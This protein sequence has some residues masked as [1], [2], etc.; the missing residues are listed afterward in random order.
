MSE[1]VVV[2]DPKGMGAFILC[3]VEMEMAGL[4]KTGRR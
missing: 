3:S 1:P 4:A 2:N